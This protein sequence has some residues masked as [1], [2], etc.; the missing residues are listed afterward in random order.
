M[1]IGILGSVLG[2]AGDLSG[3]IVL[4][5]SL[6]MNADDTDLVVGL[7]SSGAEELARKAPGA[8]VVSAFGAVPSE[9]LLGVF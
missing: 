6:P 7:N 4:S 9:V 1:R 5:C 2:V 8:R 3:K